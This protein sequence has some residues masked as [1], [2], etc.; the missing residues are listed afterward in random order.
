MAPSSGELWGH[1]LMPSMISLDCLLPNGVIVPVD[2]Y[3]ESSLEQVKRDLWRAAKDF[4]LF[5]VLQDTN[6]YIFVSITQD[7]EMEE[8]YDESR[9]LCDLRLFQPV[10]K[11]VEPKGNKE[12]K[13]LN[14]DIGI[15]I[16]IPV[17]E[18]DDMKDP[19]VFE[20]RRSVLDICLE[21]V[22]KRDE[23]GKES[24][25]KY[26]YPPEIENRPELPAGM[27]K[28]LGTEG[29]I[30]VAVWS[31]SKHHEKVKYTVRVKPY[32]IRTIT[33]IDFRT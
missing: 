19:E 20:F 24:Q 3:R 22:D 4:P 1:P 29:F 32:R 5:H 27:R 23:R 21:A 25:V 31:L 14:Y 30:N 13:M 28:K 11:L 17:H 6:S 26:A 2:S 15:A 18:F 16:G 7:G 10:L 33:C 12:E 8:F 9:R